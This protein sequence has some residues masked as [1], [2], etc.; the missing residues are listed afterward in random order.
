MDEH[1]KRLVVDL[2]MRLHRELKVRAARDGSTISEVVRRLL[3]AHLASDQL[4]GAIAE[5]M[6]M[7]HAP[8]TIMETSITKDAPFGP[9][10]RRG[11]IEDRTVHV[12]PPTSPRPK[13]PPFKDLSKTSQA[14]GRMGR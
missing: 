4:M 6:A 7:S 9:F 13:P 5:G 14:K 10:V 11:A 1:T 3:E 8:A 2:P 12:P